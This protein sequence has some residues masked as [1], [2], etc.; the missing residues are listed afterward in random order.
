MIDFEKDIERVKAGEADDVYKKLLGLN[1]NQ[2]LAD[3]EHEESEEEKS[4]DESSQASQSSD[5]KSKFV[6]SRR[7]RDE[8]PEGRRL[9]KKAI[10]E[11]QA[12]KRKSKV[13]KHVKKRKEKLVHRSNK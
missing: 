7:P 8:T 10:K 2:K 12:E 4:G 3:D 11:D 5:S 1:C 9:R 13:R 6:N